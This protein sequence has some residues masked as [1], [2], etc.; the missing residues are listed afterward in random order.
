MSEKERADGKAKF[1]QIVRNKS[2]SVK[3]RFEASDDSQIV[4]FTA[5]NGTTSRTMDNTTFEDL[6]HNG[7]VKASITL[8]IE[9]ALREIGELR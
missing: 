1:K 6:A 4:R 9:E 3:V 5:K 2:R 8:L 7:G